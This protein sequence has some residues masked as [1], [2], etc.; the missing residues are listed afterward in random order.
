MTSDLDLALQSQGLV[1]PGV[2]AFA[3]CMS[4]L[5]KMGGE[6][7]IAKRIEE[8]RP[9]LGICVGMQILFR[10]SDEDQNKTE[11]LGYFS[12]AIRRLKHGILPQIGWNDIDVGSGT[13]IFSG[14]EKERFY[15]VH[16]Y[17]VLTWQEPSERV[18]SQAA[19][20]SLSHHGEDF[21][22]AVEDGPLSGP[23]VLLLHGEPTWSFLYRKL[24]PPLAA[25]GCRVLAPDLVGCGRSD[26]PARQA[27]YSYALHVDWIAGWL[28]AL[29][30]IGR[31]HV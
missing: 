3:A 12:G 8:N 21:V 27:D 14:I 24:I 25:A 22:A 11:G 28:R 30:Q 16:S 4:A 2:G 20:V 31:A 26:K 17:G 5:R 18:G 29:D 6:R 7:V 9:V 15:F 23:V 1:V 13:K 10:S 19:M